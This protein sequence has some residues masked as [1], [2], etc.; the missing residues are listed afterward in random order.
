[1]ENIL[2]EKYTKG[3]YGIIWYYIGGPVN[4]KGIFQ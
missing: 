4:N 2:S 3:K 1:M